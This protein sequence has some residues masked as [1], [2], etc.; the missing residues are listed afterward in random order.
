[1]NVKELDKQYVANT[2]ARFPLQLTKGKGSLVYDENG[3]EYIDLGTGIAEFCQNEVHVH[4]V[5]QVPVGG[6]VCIQRINATL[7]QCSK[8]RILFFFQFHTLCFT[9]CAQ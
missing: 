6:D 9:I 2:Y 1:M 3:K 8:I 5:I 4:A 7:Q